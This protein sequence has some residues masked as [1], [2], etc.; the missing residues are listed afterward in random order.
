MIKSIQRYYLSSIPI[1]P[2]GRIMALGLFDGMHLGHIDIIEKAVDLAK[3]AG[4]RS[5][6]Q[7]FSGFDKTG[8]G[9]LYTLEERI[10]LI[11]ELDA[12]EVLILDFPEI[13][14]MSAEDYCRNIIRIY[15]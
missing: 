10:S 11:E 1:V 8:S 3:K 2:R 12:D 13:K 6:V 5:C 14:D 4:I 15:H 7:T 9:M